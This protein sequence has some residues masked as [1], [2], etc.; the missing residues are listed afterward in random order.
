MSKINRRSFFKGLGSGM[1][2]LGAFNFV[3]KPVLGSPVSTEEENPEPRIMRYNTLG[4]TGLR[5]SDISFGGADLFSE[6]VV[7]YAFD[8]GVNLFDTAETYANGKSEEYIGRGLKGVRDKAAIITKYIF[9]GSSSTSYDNLKARV[10]KSLK[11]LQTDYLDILFF[12]GLNN[13]V[14]FKDEA[15][16]EA[17]EKLKK[18]GKVRFSGFS[19]H[20]APETLAEC[21]NPEYSSFVQVVLFF[22]NHMDGKSIEH[23]VKKLHDAQIG[24]IAMKSQAGGKQGNLK[25]FVNEK[26]TYEVAALKWVLENQGIDS[27][28]ISMKTFSHVDAYI[29]ASGQKLKRNDHAVLRHYRQEV[30]NIYCRLDCTV[31]EA[32]CPNKVAISDIMRYAMYFE[33]YQ[34]EKVA[35]QEYARL[36]SKN[37]PLKCSSCSGHCNQACPYKLSVKEK[38]NHIHE[39]L[40]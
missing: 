12:Q 26:Q 19:T 28:V 14:A 8:L 30:D 1:L 32:I 22:Y 40:A 37:K 17:V 10:E 2:G 13:P 27:V 23:L 21:V 39:L 29:K 3:N 11:R 34:Q 6:N 24:T 9:R 31:C 4:K 20:N 16:K 33:D 36:D 15:L 35:I 7:R 5:V 18:E 38:L 25:S